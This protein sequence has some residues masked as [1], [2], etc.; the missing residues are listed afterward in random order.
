MVWVLGDEGGLDVTLRSCA[1]ALFNPKM[2]EDPESYCLAA[3]W[4]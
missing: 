3:E 4:K 1:M 2:H